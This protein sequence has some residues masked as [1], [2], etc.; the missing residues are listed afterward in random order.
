V[1]E[2]LRGCGLNCDDEA[3]LPHYEVLTPRV[4]D[5]KAVPPYG[6][7]LRLCTDKPKVVR[8]RG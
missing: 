3:V 1:S 5:S 7:V 4:D 2:I 6:K 8:P